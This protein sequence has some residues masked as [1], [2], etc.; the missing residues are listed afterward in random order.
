MC[1]HRCVVPMV[2]I[3]AAYRKSSREDD[4]RIPQRWCVMVVEAATGLRGL[5]LSLCGQV[6][7]LCKLLVLTLMVKSSKR[8][9]T[10]GPSVQLEPA[11]LALAR[12]S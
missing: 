7:L 9:S 2:L 5:T 6:G 4:G 3:L 10:E 12:V 11:A 8:R 1:I